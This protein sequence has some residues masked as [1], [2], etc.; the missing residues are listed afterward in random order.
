MNLKVFEDFNS[1]K[2]KQIY[3][4]QEKSFIFTLYLL[5]LNVIQTRKKY[6][7]KVTWW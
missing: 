4:L 6:R 1:K 2:N 5:A 3:K 7:N